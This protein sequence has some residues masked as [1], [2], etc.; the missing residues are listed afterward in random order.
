ML[1]RLLSTGE[2]IEY[3][4]SL[5]DLKSKLDISNEKFMYELS[6]F[7]TEKNPNPNVI[8][9]CIANSDCQV[10]LIEEEFA[11]IYKFKTVN[12][13]FEF[14][15]NGFNAKKELKTPFIIVRLNIRCK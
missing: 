4:S 1:S 9:R 12:K 11:N 13:T 10:N 8:M 14:L 2:K 3:I 15:I 7:E 5:N 6:N